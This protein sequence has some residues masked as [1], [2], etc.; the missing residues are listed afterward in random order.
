VISEK[1]PFIYHS[2]KSRH[3]LHA[4]DQVWRSEIAEWN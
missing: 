2:R 1:R 4:G 3:I